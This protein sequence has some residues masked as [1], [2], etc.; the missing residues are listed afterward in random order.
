MDGVGGEVWRSAYILRNCAV[1]I[2]LVLG[3]LHLGL[4]VRDKDMANCEG[5]EFAE[6]GTL[7][8]SHGCGLKIPCPL[9]SADVCR[10][11]AECPRCVRRERDELSDRIFKI[12]QI[13][14]RLFMHANKLA[15]K[16]RTPELD[17]AI[18]GWADVHKGNI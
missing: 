11:W 6:P 2:A 7:I 18:M 13:G 15:I 9:C 16:D 1:A 5:G 4:Q 17:E 8:K 3:V 14:D 10:H 12:K